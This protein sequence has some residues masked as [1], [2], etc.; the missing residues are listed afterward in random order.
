MTEYTVVTVTDHGLD[1]P[2]FEFRQR[3]EIMSS[4]EQSRPAIESNQPL[5]PVTSHEDAEEG[6]IVGLPSVL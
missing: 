3:Q 6:W 4:P 1:D 5:F 2:G